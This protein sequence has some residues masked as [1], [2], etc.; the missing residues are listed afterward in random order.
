MEKWNPYGETLKHYEND[1]PREIESDPKWEEGI[2]KKLKLKNFQD[3]KKINI[4]YLILIYDGGG[5][6]AYCKAMWMDISL[7][8]NLNKTF[9]WSSKFL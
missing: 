6:R 5:R 7:Y 1:Y 9:R 4:F 8:L 3:K 2:A